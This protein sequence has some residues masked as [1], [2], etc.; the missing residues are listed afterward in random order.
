MR[1]SAPERALEEL[2]HLAAALADERDDDDVGLG[3]ARDRA[4]QR[5][6]ADARAGEEAD[7]LPL[8]ER[9]Q[10]VEHA[11][12]GRERRGDR[13]A[14]ERRRRIAVDRRRARPSIG[15]P[16]VDRAPEAVDHAPEQRLARAHLRSGPPVAST[17]SSG[18]TPARAPSGIAIGLAAVE[19][20]DLAR[21]RL[22]AALHAHDVADAH[23]GQREAQAQP[24]HAEDAPGRAHAS[25]ARRASP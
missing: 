11:H 5:A 2:A 16:A 20:D 25:A 23:A 19:A 15:G 10:A 22:A 14:L 6:L 24:R 7:A 8:A 12:A 21:E 13:A 18:P 1:P 3:A 9:E 4:E 17:S